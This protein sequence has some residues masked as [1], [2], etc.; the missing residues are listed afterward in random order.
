M[1]MVDT[2]VWVT[3]LMV[4]NDESDAVT[5]YLKINLSSLSA[6]TLGYG[7]VTP[8]TPWGKLFCIVYCMVGVPLNL[9]LN[10]LIGIQL[11]TVLRKLVKMSDQLVY[12]KFFSIMSIFAYLVFLTTFFVF[13]PAFVFSVTENWTYNEALYYSF[14][15]LSTIG[16][17]DYVASKCF[18]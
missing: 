11:R 15:S 7:N 14:V 12:S 1:V 4:D 13:L 8:L 3:R 17:G 18:L 16:F 2:H 5:A 6:V 9:T 10:R